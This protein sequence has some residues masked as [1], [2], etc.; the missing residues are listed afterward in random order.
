MIDLIQSMKI[1]FELYKCISNIRARNRRV[2]NRRSRNVGVW[3]RVNK[4][5]L[6]I[7][8]HLTD[9]VNIINFDDINGEECEFE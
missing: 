5:G 4:R 3:V 9:M 6:L 8:E 2:Y 1:K 7:Y